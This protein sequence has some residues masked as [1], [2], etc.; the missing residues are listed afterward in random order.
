[1][2]DRLPERAT[3]VVVIDD[4]P[5][6]VEMTMAPG[7]AVEGQYADVDHALAPAEPSERERVAPAGERPPPRQSGRRPSCDRLMPVGGAPPPPRDRAGPLVEATMILSDLVPDE[8]TGEPIRSETRSGRAEF[9][10]L[11]GAQW[12]RW[13]VEGVAESGGPPDIG[14]LGAVGD[15]AS[16]GT[17]HPPPDLSQGSEYRQHS[18]GPVL[19]SP[20]QSEAL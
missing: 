6:I 14:P 1:M 12:A 10:C 13:G 16:A 11:R 4:H 2:T 3:T 9:V 19:S 20:A 17:A 18:V 15:A 5:M 7:V 8:F